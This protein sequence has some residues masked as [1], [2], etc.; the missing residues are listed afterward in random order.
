M[1][2]QKTQ[3]SRQKSERAKNPGSKD[4]AGKPLSEAM[5]DET[6]AES[7]PASD[8]PSW[9]TGR[10]IHNPPGQTKDDE[11]IRLPTEELNDKA[12]ELN[13]A[14]HDSMTREQLILAIRGRLAT[15]SI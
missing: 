10:D 8:P 2:K 15:N 7:F 14:G 9:T 4:S 3:S 11:L 1:T 13:I 5:I 6:V 12:A